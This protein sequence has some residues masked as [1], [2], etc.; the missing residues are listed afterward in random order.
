MEINGPSLLP[1][2]GRANPVFLDKRDKGSECVVFFGGALSGTGDPE[3][4]RTERSGVVMGRRQRMR[5]VHVSWQIQDMLHSRETKKAFA[6]SS[7]YCTGRFQE[8]GSKLQR[9][10]M[11]GGR[12]R[13]SPCV[14]YGVA[15]YIYEDL[16]LANS[17]P[18][19]ANG[20]HHL[21]I[22]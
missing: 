10:E 12:W 9:E 11:L 1:G 17:R 16:R 3:G 13:L 4:D 22:G 21:K 6:M 19:A 18:V 15:A 8:R 20:C 7:P 5:S 2:E 14:R